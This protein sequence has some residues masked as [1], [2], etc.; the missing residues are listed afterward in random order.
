M[1]SKKEDNMMTDTITISKAAGKL[2]LK[3]TCRKAINSYYKKTP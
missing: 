1:K 3:H 2:I